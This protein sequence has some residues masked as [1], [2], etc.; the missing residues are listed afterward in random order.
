MRLIM[1]IITFSFLSLI[2]LA[3]DTA[4][5]HSNHGEPLN[6]DQAII[7]AS[8][9]V[10]IIVEDSE[11]IEGRKLDSS[12]TKVTDKKIFKKSLR[13]FIVSFSHS[14]KQRTLYVLLNIYGEYLDANFNGKFKGL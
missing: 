9:D 8:K 10:N 4:L 1:S 11:S 3:P 6:D 5:G 7:K 2:M 12:W 13:Y 14:G